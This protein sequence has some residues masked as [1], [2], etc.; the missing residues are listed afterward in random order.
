MKKIFCK[1]I[2]SILIFLI[3]VSLPQVS[4]R[5]TNYPQP[6]IVNVKQNLE[7]LIKDVDIDGDKK[8]TIDDSGKRGIKRFWLISTNGKRYELVGTYYLS[9]LLKELKFAQDQGFTNTQID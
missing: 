7:R 3:I 9:N 1:A 2:I 6:I 4:L 5:A 8:I